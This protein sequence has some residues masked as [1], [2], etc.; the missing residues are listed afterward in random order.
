MG[1]CFDKT[2]LPAIK[3]IVKAHMSYDEVKSQLKIPSTWGTMITGEEFKE[4]ATVNKR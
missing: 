2:L 3:K 1:D 4:R